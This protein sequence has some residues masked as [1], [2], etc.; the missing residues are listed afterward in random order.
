MI[1][2]KNVWNCAQRGS[3]VYAESLD[4]KYDEREASCYIF[5]GSR[6]AAGEEAHD[7]G[8]VAS[9]MFSATSHA[10]LTPHGRKSE[11]G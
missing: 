4:A 7:Q 8:V 9:A 11:E 6:D 5:W 3:I 1:F 2:Q 10:R